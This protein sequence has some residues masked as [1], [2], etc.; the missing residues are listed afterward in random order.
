MSGGVAKL[1]MNL[2]RLD[3]A[4][5]FRRR[6]SAGGRRRSLSDAVRGNRTDERQACWL[7]LG[8]NI[9]ELSSSMFPRERG[10]QKLAN[11]ISPRFQQPQLALSRIVLPGEILNVARL[12]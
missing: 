3:G 12:G 4:G 2:L 6:C 1:Q 10:M 8:R 7:R 9:V 11:Y 5:E